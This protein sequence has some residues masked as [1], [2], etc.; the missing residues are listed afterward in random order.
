MTIR[1]VGLTFTQQVGKDDGTNGSY[2]AE[3]GF[4]RRAQKLR[5]VE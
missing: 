5:R 3:V 2:T 4:G 1:A